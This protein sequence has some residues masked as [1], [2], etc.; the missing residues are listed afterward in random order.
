MGILK[1]YRTP[2]RL[3]NDPRIRHLL[4][5]QN[6]DSYFV[7]WF[8]LKELACT[9]EDDGCL[10][11]APGV[12]LLVRDIAK[13]CGH[14]KKFVERALDVFEQSDL[15][16]RDEKGM[17]RVLVWDDMQTLLRDENRREKARQR[18]SRYRQRHRRPRE[19]Q[20]VE[21][22]DM[23]EQETSMTDSNVIAD[24][25]HQDTADQGQNQPENPEP[26]TEVL[27]ARC[28]P[29]SREPEL[30]VPYSPEQDNRW[31]CASVQHY[32]QSFGQVSPRTEEQLVL[33]EK[34]WGEK[35]VTRAIDVARDNGK[36]HIRYISKI[37][38]N[39]VPVERKEDRDD[40]W[41]CGLTN[42][43]FERMLHDIERE[44]Y[45][46]KDGVQSDS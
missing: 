13:G 30:P 40:Y 39:G 4:G 20:P 45:L 27:P 7:I 3:F 35:S 1:W 36:S 14:S 31:N 21:Q 44:G 17:I 26:A 43:E 2:T 37:I 12:P 11:I 10:S 16:S 33:L 15:I 22:P 29:A 9:A 24:Q 41:G 6:G 28:M 34:S 38:E 25:G 46:C 23:A 8:Y 42:E 5:F 19:E 32:I 18:A